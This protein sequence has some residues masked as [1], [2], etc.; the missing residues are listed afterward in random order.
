MSEPQTQPQTAAEKTAAEEGTGRLRA[1]SVGIGEFCKEP[2]APA[3]NELAKK[4]GVAP[5]AL[6]PAL[7]DTL[8]E[9]AAK[10]E[11]PAEQK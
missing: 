11:K 6:A 10:E 8:A 3:Y 1:F 9:A 4:A 5:E 2:G 7:V